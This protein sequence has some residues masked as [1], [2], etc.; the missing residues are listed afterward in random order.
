MKSRRKQFFRVALCA[1][2]GHW[3]RKLK[4]LWCQLWFFLPYRAKE[5]FKWIFFL[6]LIERYDKLNEKN[7]SAWMK[8]SLKEEFFDYNDSAI[9]FHRKSENCRCWWKGKEEKSYRLWKWMQISLFWLIAMVLLFLAP[10]RV[11]I[12]YQNP[13]E[14][15]L[16]VFFLADDKMLIR[17]KDNEK[18]SD[19]KFSLRTTRKK[20]NEMN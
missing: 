16:F 7:V 20:R 5:N 14:K 13:T 11:I 6:H 17:I 10:L 9:P 12:T 15:A 4:Y 1:R 19:E 3:K 8:N 18:L 2:D